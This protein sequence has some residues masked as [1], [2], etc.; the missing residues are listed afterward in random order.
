MENLQEQIKL[1]VELQGLDSHMFRLEDSLEQIPENIN[2][3]DEEFKESTA[4]LKTLEDGL[5]S[6]QVKRKEKEVDLEAREGTIKKYQSQLNQVKTNKEYSALQD[7]IGRNRAD[8]SMVEEDIIRIFD[9]IDVE[10]KKIGQEKELLKQKE[11]ESSEK[12]K[13]L[14]EEEA[15]VNLELED[16]KKKRTELA[17]KVDK[18]I[19]S[20]YEKIVR[21][22]GGLAVVPVHNDAC[23]GCFRVLPP[24]VI[25]EIRMKQGIIMCDNCARML[26]IEE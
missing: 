6:L 2:R 13:K 17:A 24:Q 10:N 7:E 19:L 16:V 22:R 18:N 26:Y 9:Q 15:R 1:L 4:S 11:A 20:K 14:K 5:K 8:N 21:N 3:M 23:Q 12:K 25:N